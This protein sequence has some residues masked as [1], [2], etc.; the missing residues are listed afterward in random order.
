MTVTSLSTLIAPAI[1]EEDAKEYFSNWDESHVAARFMTLTYPVNSKYHEQ[2]PAVVHVDGTARPQVIRKEDNP[3][4]Y[5]IIDS[6][7][8]LTNIPLVINTSFNQHN[9]PIVCKPDE[10]IA[11]LL[12]NCIDALA[13]GNYWVVRQNDN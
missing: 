5:K 3:R 8:K 6:F 2:I 10:A 1:L 9:E 13:I 11:A 12:N 7:K 4:F